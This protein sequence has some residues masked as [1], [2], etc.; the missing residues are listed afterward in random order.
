[1]MLLRSSCV[2]LSSLFLLAIVDVSLAFST[3]QS[4]SRRSPSST[5]ALNVGAVYNDASED[6]AVADGIYLM[7]RAQVCA[8]SDSCSLEEAQTFLDDILHQQKECIGAGVLSTKAA[9]CDNIDVTAEL[10]ANL[11]DKIEIQ[12]RPRAVAKTTVH[13]FNIMMGVYVTSLILHGVAAVPNVPVDSPFLNTDFSSTEE[14]STLGVSAFLPQEWIWAVRDGYLPT[15]MTEWFR[16]GGLVVDTS[17][18]DTKVVAFTPQEWFFSIQNGSFGNILHENMRY[19]GLVVDSSFDNTETIPM[20]LQDVLWSI[21]G[22]Y[23]GTAAEHFF[24]NGGV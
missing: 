2:T 20:T 18:F 23:V 1:M 8:S 15:L 21:Q 16:N 11:R 13:L 19:G 4:S 24:R 22:G 5:S 6:C 10:V 17:A 12:R 3:S 14:A 9:I 7:N